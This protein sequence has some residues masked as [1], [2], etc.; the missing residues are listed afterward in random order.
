MNSFGFILFRPLVLFPISHVSICF[1]FRNAGHE[2]VYILISWCFFFPFFLCL[3]ARIS[4]P[5]CFASVA[6]YHIPPHDSFLGLACL[7]FAGQNGRWAG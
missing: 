1:V 6:F 5:H 2:K 3:C 4:H 7:S